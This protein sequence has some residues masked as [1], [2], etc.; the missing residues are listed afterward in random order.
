MTAR[1]LGAEDNEALLAL[2]ST[3]TTGSTEFR[4]DRSPDFFALGRRFGETAVYGAFDG[5]TLVASVSVSKQRRFIEG[6]ATV[7]T[8]LHDVRSR[9]GDGK[10]AFVLLA[11]H[12][13]R[14]ES[15]RASWAFGTVLTSNPIAPR[16]VS[17]IGRLMGG[18]RAIGT[19]DHVALQPAA[20]PSGL[21]VAEVDAPTGTG[22]YLQWA[23]RRSFALADPRACS[24][25]SG[26][27]LVAVQ[28]GEAVA[29]TFAARETDR[30]IV[31]TATGREVD[32]GYLS[33]MCARD[34]ADEGSAEAAFTEHVMCAPWALWRLVCR[35]RVRPSAAFGNDARGRPGEH[36]LLSSTTYAFGSAPSNL[37]IELA[38]LTMV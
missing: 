29:V 31:A 30:R 19:V 25:L 28:E 23:S 2:S 13:L 20:R 4:V 1:R 15:P 5:P 12:V 24:M 37:A 7:T 27:W 26:R 3:R 16:L 9:P 10:L 32:V 8:Y 14:C 33:F 34:G 21:E 35:G 36:V 18:A 11:R 6:A 17:I 38:E 22:L